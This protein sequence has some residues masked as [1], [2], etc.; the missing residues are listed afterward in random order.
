MGAHAWERAIRALRGAWGR[1]YDG[2]MKVK[3]SVTLS[4]ELLESLQERLGPKGNRSEFIEEAIRHRLRDLRRAERDARDAVIYERM[5]NDP[6]LRKEI[7]DNLDLQEELWNAENC[8]E[9]LDPLGIPAATG[10]S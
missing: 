8:T 5:A 3:T 9:S 4:E 7:L 2:G 10:S 6:E 1:W